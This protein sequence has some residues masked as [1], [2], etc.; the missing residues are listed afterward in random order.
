[1]TFEQELSMKTEEVEEIIERFLPAEEGLQ[2]TIFTAMNYSVRAGGK[3]LRPLIA[4]ETF[5]LFDGH[6][7]IIE[8]FVAA[9]EFIHTSSLIH[10]DLPCMDN[11]TLR[12]GLETTWHKFGEDMGVLAGDALMMYA[13]ETAATAF[14]YNL[15]IKNVG[16]AMHVLAKKTGIYG[17]IGGQTVDVEE[18]GKVLT[19]EKME[20]IYDL[21][22]CALLEASMMCGAILAD[23]SHEDVQNVER[24]A[25]KVGMAFQIKDDILDVTSTDEELGKNVGSDEKNEKTTYVSLYGLEEAEKKVA[26]LTNE[27]VALMQNLTGEN[28][29]LEN[30]LISLISRKK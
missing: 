5:R 3:R 15:N 4:L 1:M 10:D 6:G 8:P 7:R 21:K 2:K 18:T 20:F 26:E 11:D 25:K 24:I 17:M 12:R 28:R 13:M 30:L 19:P 27:A 14:S 23:A 22:T 9:V 29:F 16:T